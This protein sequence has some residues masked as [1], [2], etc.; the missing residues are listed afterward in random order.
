MK[1]HT[2]PD[3]APPLGSAAEYVAQSTEP[4]EVIDVYSPAGAALYHWLTRTDNSEVRELVSALRHAPGEILELACGSGRIT[5]PLLMHGRRVTAL[6]SSATMLE[7]LKNRVQKTVPIKAGAL[8]AIRGNMADFCFGKT[9]DAILLGTSSVSLLSPNDRTSMFRSV[10]SHLADHGRFLMTSLE[11]TDEA[12]YS[13]PKDEIIDR[14]DG[15][16]RGEVLTL[17]E[18]LDNEARRRHVS[19]YCQSP[20]RRPR[21]FTTVTEI[22]S[23]DTLRKE[24]KEFG[25][26]VHSERGI[27]TGREG[28]LDVLLECE[29]VQ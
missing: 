28:R 26:R 23:L 15:P 14:L 25:M 9:F 27:S 20:N 29:K 6:D 11:F 19:I 12:L 10:R 18:H 16:E 1:I 24:I 2:E 21:I 4:V 17:F 7:I 8:T 13:G 3:A 22:I 5:L